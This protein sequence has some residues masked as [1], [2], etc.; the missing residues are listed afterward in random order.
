MGPR[1]RR[2]AAGFLA[3][4]SV[5]GCSA[6]NPGAIDRRGQHAAAWAPPPPARCNTPPGELLEYW[7]EAPDAELLGTKT[8]G[9]AGQ[10]Q[11][12]YYAN[13]CR[14]LSLVE[15][16]AHL[17]S[18][19]NA[20]RALQVNSIG[21]EQ[22]TV[23]IWL[24][25]RREYGTPLSLSAVDAERDRRALELP[26]NLRATL[27]AL[28]GSFALVGTVSRQDALALAALDQVRL[29]FVYPRY[30]AS[31]ARDVTRALALG[32]SAVHSQGTIAVFDDCAEGAPALPAHASFADAAGV[33]CLS[34]TH[35]SRVSALAF[36]GLPEGARRLAAGLTLATTDAPESLAAPALWAMQ[37]QNTDVLVQTI[38][39]GVFEGANDALDMLLV[40]AA[41]G[42]TILVRASGNGDPTEPVVHRV[43]G[44]LDVGAV[45]D[46]DAPL[47][48][49]RMVHPYSV[50]GDRRGVHLLDNGIVTDLEGSSEGTSFSAPRTAATALR[51]LPSLASSP[52]R[53]LGIRARLLGWARPETCPVDTMEPPP[54]A[55]DSACGSG[56][57]DDL[58]G[59]GA[60]LR[61]D[62]DDRVAERLGAQATTTLE[63][64]A[65][66]T[67]GPYRMRAALAFEAEPG[68]GW[69]DALRPA[70]DLDLRVINS[71]GETVANAQ[72][73][74]SDQEVTTWPAAAGETFRVVVE[75]LGGNSIRH[76]VLA[77]S[78]K[79]K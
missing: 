56:I 32:E 5:A 64:R 1:S 25:S 48:S 78:A 9:G 31:A 65:P 52:F 49:M 59:A 61:G 70:A 12:R 13:D 63:V 19:A 72:S 29:F 3:F 28:S 66:A 30:A 62:A 39:I 21:D 4:A 41:Y 17:T 15:V 51:M 10:T 40:E 53:P 26:P 8:L 18:A 60:A 44:A 42:R 20:R 37:R 57:T 6:G 77:W 16:A 35:G 36:A 46:H 76:A 14:E 34:S 27:T 47:M 50:F 11:I 43:A 54:L 7:R 24:G 45:N 38:H 2:S 75:R 74:D 22:V 68:T 58:T 69:I 71:A 23:Q 55:E 79:K 33:T 73:F 67:G